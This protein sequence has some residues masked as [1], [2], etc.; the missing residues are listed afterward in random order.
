MAMRRPFDVRN[1]VVAPIFLSVYSK[2]RKQRIVHVNVVIPIIGPVTVG[3]LCDTKYC[4]RYR[5]INVF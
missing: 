4:V 3:I 5:L 1:F 2:K